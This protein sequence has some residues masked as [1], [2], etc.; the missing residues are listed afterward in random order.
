M[1]SLPTHS[2]RLSLR[3]AIWSLAR[4]EGRSLDFVLVI[5]IYEVLLS[6]SSLD[7]QIVFASSRMI[8]GNPFQ[9]LDYRAKVPNS[10]SSHVLSDRNTV[11]LSGF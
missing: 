7:R 6:I 2:L 8:P 3:A 4:K 10:Y 9:D 11:R 1:P 5:D